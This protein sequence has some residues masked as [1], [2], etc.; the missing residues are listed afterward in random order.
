MPDVARDIIENPRHPDAAGV[1]DCQR[2]VAQ[3]PA[4]GALGFF[5]RV[6]PLAEA[7]VRHLAVK[8]QLGFEVG[9]ESPAP[10]PVLQAAK[11]GR[12]AGSHRLSM[13]D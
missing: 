1:L 5:R 4:A 6:A 12:H 8:L 3:N 7:L 13:E 11:K 2:G 9:L 10:E